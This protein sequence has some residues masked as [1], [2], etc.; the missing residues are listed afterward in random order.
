MSYYSC[1]CHF[2]ITEVYC[3]KSILIDTLKV[4]FYLISTITTTKFD[5]QVGLTIERL[6]RI[7]N[8]KLAAAYKTSVYELPL[9][10]GTSSVNC[11]SIAENGNLTLEYC[12]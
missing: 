3:K 5:L 6:Q 2:S 10:H 11:A 8:P 7:Y 4:L 9:F 1:K 12:I